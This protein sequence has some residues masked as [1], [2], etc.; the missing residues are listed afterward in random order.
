MLLTG[1]QTKK[2]VLFV[3]NWS[4]YLDPELKT[5]FEQENNCIIR[6]STYESNE[7]LL[8]KILSSKESY[9]IVFPS[10]DHVTIMKMKNLLEPIDKNKLNNY[11]NLDTNILLKAQ[12]FDPENQFAIPYFWGLTGLMYN[13]THIPEAV[14]AS[15]SWNVLAD[16][17]FSGKSKITMLDDAR[18]VIGAALITVGKD[19][20]DTSKEALEAAMK[21]LEIWDRN[22]TQ[23]DS[24]SYKNEVPDGTT[25]ISQAY[26]GDA[27]QVMSENPSIDF[28]LPSEGASLWIDSMVILKS[29]QNKDLAYKF[30]DFLLDAENAFTN[31]Q[32]TSY[33]TPNQKAYEKLDD[34]IKNNKLIYPDKEYLDRCFMLRFLGDDVKRIDT[35]YELIKT[36]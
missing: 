35:L 5:K 26:N 18:E 27:L 20:N 6:L 7:N 16:T 17:H 34:E 3:S 22:I 13:K 1:C 4:D 31:A 30:I 15:N 32:Y 9:D 2:K 24:D 25:W 36:N 14:L 28:F 10:G 33:A 21:I 23:F 11:A 19:P 12:S 29:S 8:T